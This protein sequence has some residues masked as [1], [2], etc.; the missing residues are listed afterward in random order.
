[1]VEIPTHLVAALK[2]L[3]LLESEANVYTALVLL[4]D[5][6]VKELQNLLDLSKPSIYDGLRELENKGFIILTN[7]RPA[8]YQ[9]IPPEVALDMRINAQIKA[10]DVAIDSIAKLKDEKGI[11]T[12]HSNLWYVFGQKHFE[13]KI[14]DM[15]RNAKKNIYCITSGKYLD[16]IEH[17]ARS[18]MDIDLVIITDGM[19]ERERL[20]RI[21]AKSRLRFRIVS[22]S[23]LSKAASEQQGDNRLKSGPSAGVPLEMQDLDSLFI[24]IID[25]SEMLII[26]PI[27]EMSSNAITM[28]SKAMVSMI[29][30]GLIG[31]YDEVKARGTR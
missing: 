28:K 25:D 1:M 30:A 21:S 6:E 14:K 13:S 11:E 18:K 29:K 5:A 7:P 10:K 16:L 12:Q 23:E 20:D 31:Q 17:W 15:L 9:A 22:N 3:G 8:T 24:L 2:E 4:H 27:R 26:P 19:V